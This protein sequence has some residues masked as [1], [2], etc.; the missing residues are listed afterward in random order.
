MSG[1]VV[2]DADVLRQQV[3]ALEKSVAV[4]EA[5][6]EGERKK[7]EEHLSHLA[8]AEAA[9]KLGSTEETFDPDALR[10]A[11]VSIDNNIASIGGV[12]EMTRKKLTERSADLA[13]ANSIL[14]AHDRARGRKKDGLPE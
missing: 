4:L 13:V 9:R 3:S 7:R 14:E 2:Y 5:G 11:L 10:R 12:L 6:L 8:V 1:G